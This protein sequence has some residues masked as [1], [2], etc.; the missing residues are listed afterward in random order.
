[1]SK[2]RGTG[3]VRENLSIAFQVLREHK[4]RSA[5]I[6]LGVGIGVAALMGMVSILLGLGEKIRHD[7]NSSEQTVVELEKFDFMVGGFDEAM[8]HRKDITEEDSKALRAECSTLEHTA[9]VVQGQPHT[10]HAGNEKSRMISVVGSEPSLFYAWNLDL[11]AGRMFTDEEVFHRAK[12]IVLGHSPRRDLF[13]T[14]DPIGKKVRVENDEYTVIGTF[15]ERKTLFGALGENFCLIPYTTYMATMWK[16]YDGRVV[17]GTL[18]PGISVEAAKDD[19]IRVMRVRHHL[20]ANQADDFA[21][22]TSDAALELLERITGPIAGVLAAISSIALLVGGIG[23][24]NM[25]LVSVTERTG[26]IGIRKAVGATRQDILWQ[27]LIEA[28]ALTG[29]GGIFGITL[30]LGAALAVSGL[31]GLPSNQSPAY[32]LLAVL[33]SIAIGV[34]FGIYPANRASKLDPV[35]AMSYAKT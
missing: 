14:T 9:Y 24:M 5:L 8:L 34:F 3:V 35:K 7:I 12:V 18:R 2:Q 15:V 22:T 23:V 25:M 30:G 11:E 13:P 31:T 17:L 21:V 29:L 26:E 16:Q 32:I 20:K 28:G 4:L 19:V 1:M 6:I 10:L 27:F 33:F